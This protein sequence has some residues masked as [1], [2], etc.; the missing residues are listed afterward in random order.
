MQN[1][2]IELQI[3]TPPIAHEQHAKNV[4]IH[5]HYHEWPAGPVDLSVHTEY[6]QFLDHIEH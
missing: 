5:G 2:T 4:E 6:Q 3:S 1:E